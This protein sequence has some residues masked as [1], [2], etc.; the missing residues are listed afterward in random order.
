MFRLSSLGPASI[1]AVTCTLAA[2]GCGSSSD[3]ASSEVVPGRALSVRSAAG[4]AVGTIRL[5]GDQVS[6]GKNAFFVDFD[7]TATEVTSV[8]TLMPVHGHGSTTPTVT[9][10]G[11]Q[12]RISDVV[13]TMPGLWEVRLDI[14]V[15]GA[16]DRLVFDVD[17]P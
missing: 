5:D 17:A 10:N 7:P 15:A 14:D 13:F 9:R 4:L 11:A 6:E 16:P 1:F 12:Y 2:F 3:S 8:S